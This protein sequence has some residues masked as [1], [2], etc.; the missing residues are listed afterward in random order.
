MTVQCGKGTYI[1]AIARDLG[2]TL[3]DADG[4]PAGG[5]LSALQRLQNGAFCQETAMTFSEI[6]H[7]LNVRN[8]HLKSGKLA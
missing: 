8:T 5:H 6:E 2:A 4:V 3:V 7:H 1:R